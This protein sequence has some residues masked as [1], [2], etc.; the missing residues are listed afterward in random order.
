MEID[1]RLAP[2]LWA[3]FL[4]GLAAFGFPLLGLF[5]RP[6]MIGGL[7]VLVVYLFVV[8]AAFIVVLACLVERRPPR[9]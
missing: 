1:P 4:A 6:A 7:P 2:R 8:W 9:R 3:L 5:S